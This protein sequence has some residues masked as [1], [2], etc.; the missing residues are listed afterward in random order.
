MK[1]TPAA[2]I[3]TRASPSRGTGSGRSTERSCSGPPGVATRIAFMAAA[4]SILDR[5]RSVRSRRLLSISGAFLPALFNA[6]CA[7]NA[8]P[9]A[10]T[11]RRM[12]EAAERYVKLVL[13]VGQH[14]Q[15]YVD[16]SHG[17]AEWKREAERQ[18][19]PLR[20]IDGEAARLIQQLPA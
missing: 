20:A 8:A 2:S 18:K 4:L 12:N 17:P 1:L 7:S 10:D 14:D 3:R 19:R 16:A 13:A 6:G 15:D 11:V 9:V 5:L